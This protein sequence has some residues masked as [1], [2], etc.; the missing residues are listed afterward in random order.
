[1]SAAVEVKILPVVAGAEPVTYRG[2]IMETTMVPE[3]YKD[4][5]QY[6]QVPALIIEK[7]EGREVV[8]QPLKVWGKSIHVRKI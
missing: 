4:V 2:R 3:F 6:L 8:V 7:A 1:M 5:G